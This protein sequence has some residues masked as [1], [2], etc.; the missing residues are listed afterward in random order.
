MGEFLV[1]SI[2]QV[3]AALGQAADQGTINAQ[4]IRTAIEATDQTLARLRAVG[5]GT[6]HPLVAE[7]IARTEQSRQR[8]VEATALLQSSAQA[9]RN[10]L[11][12][13]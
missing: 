6:N 11:N 3:K 10:Y 4:Q 7:A 1:A 8:L 5:A 9:A 2:E 12:A 13:L